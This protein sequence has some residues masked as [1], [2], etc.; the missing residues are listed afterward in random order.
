MSAA[1]SV[2]RAAKS[3]IFEIFHKFLFPDEFLIAA[4]SKRP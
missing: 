4:D 2:S 3:D 1:V